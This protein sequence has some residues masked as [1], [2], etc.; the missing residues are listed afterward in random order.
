M[1]LSHFDFEFSYELFDALIVFIIFPD[2]FLFELHIL[3]IDELKVHAHLTFL[4]VWTVIVLMPLKLR[5]LVVKLF[6]VLSVDWSTLMSV[7]MSFLIV[8]LAVETRTSVVN[9]F[10]QIIHRLV[11]MY[12]WLVVLKYPFF[13][14]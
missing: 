13:Q 7:F 12:W 1:K 10:D 3:C 8:F 11:F 6:V 9:S 5:F 4:D 2:L 14:W